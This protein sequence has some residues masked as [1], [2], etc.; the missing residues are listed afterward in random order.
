MFS[1]KSMYL[2]HGL[3]YENHLECLRVIF[4][5]LN[6]IFKSIIMVV[7]TVAEANVARKTKAIAAVAAELQKCAEHDNTR[8][9]PNPMH[10]IHLIVWR[11]SWG[12]IIWFKVHAVDC[13]EGPP[14]PPVFTPFTVRLFLWFRVG[15]LRN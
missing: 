4:K 3:Q 12:R 15:F 11:T 9:R 2:L 13:S 5:I 1:N 6:D 10:I 7:V 14:S 8:P